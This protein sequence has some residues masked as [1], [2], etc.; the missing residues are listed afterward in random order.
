M[1]RD[2]NFR[3]DDD[4]Q[5]DTDD[6]R[7]R[8][9]PRAPR[10]RSSQEFHFPPRSS[11]TR[12]SSSGRASQRGYPE[13]EQP[14][15]RQ[16][17][18]FREEAET[19]D[20][21]MQRRRIARTSREEA[22]ERRRNRAR[23]TGQPLYPPQQPQPSTRDRYEEVDDNYMRP[24]QRPQRPPTRE[25]IDERYNER[26][27]R[28]YREP[29]EAVYA[30]PA[31]SQ[32]A[33]TRSDTPTRAPRQRRSFWSTLLI[34]CVGGV[35]TIALI[36]GIVVFVLFRALPTNIPGIGGIGVS[37]YKSQP[38][39]IALSL[40][41]NTQLQVTNKVGD[42]S[43]AVSSDPNVTQASLTAVKSVQAKSSS[44]ANT[45]FGRISI[46]PTQGTSSPGCPQ[47]SC[48]AVNVTAPQNSGDVVNLSITLP[49]SISAPATGAATFML[50]ASTVAGNL[51]AQNFN[52]V[53]TLSTDTGN[54]QA[55]HGL[56]MAGSCLQT[57]TGTITFNGFLG[58]QAKSPLN[59]CQP[60]TSATA[61][62]A[63][64]QSSQPWFSMKVGN[65]NIDAT[66]NG[67]SVNNVLL[68]A[69]VFNKGKIT[70]T[71]DIKPQQN[72]DGSATYYGP[73]VPNTQPVALLTMNM[74]TGTIAVKKA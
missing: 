24:A 30:R 12:S 46:T 13:T 23:Q 33:R 9:Q 47:A 42:V 41:N 69:N 19:T 53:L 3:Q 1:N 72:A 5:V 67:P 54:V 14:R 27:A 29:D 58:T 35:I 25:D 16:T 11:G 8:R 6:E 7:S 64:G 62:P 70:S 31:P 56:L 15:S 2:K 45:E 66:L 59:P 65:G 20:T 49:G 37:T 51:S 10:P 52:G 55:T 57:R 73:L 60:N 63:T 36:V 32:R 68:D 21:E 43:I 40:Q 50:T 74:N 4:Y 18:D 48:L 44:E 71:F 26:P 38:Q 34:G 17:R 61:T 22:Y 28:R 39:T